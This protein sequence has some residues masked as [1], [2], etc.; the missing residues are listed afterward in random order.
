MH[1]RGRVAQGAV[2]LLS[3]VLACRPAAPISAPAEPVAAAR[4]EP[5]RPTP[6]SAPDR[7]APVRVRPVVSAEAPPLAREFRGVW[8]ASVA[9]IDWPSKRTLSTAQQQAELIALLDRAAALKLNAVLFQIR[10]AA[11]ALYASKIEPWSEYLTGAQGR[12]PVPYWDPLEFAIREAHARHLELHAW[13][14]P[15]RARHTD[16]KSPLARTHIARTNPTLVKPYARY[17]WMDPGEPAVRARTLRVVLDVVKRYDV[18]GVHIDDYFYPY[19][20]NDRRGRAI[21]FPDDRSWKRY[22]REGGELSRA[23]WRRRNVDLLVQALDEG[24]HKAKP[25]VRF[26]ISPFGIWRPGY[27][28]Q[29]RGFDAYEKLY[30]DA[31]KWLREGWVDYFTPQLYWPTTKREQA[32]PA[33]LDWWV[34]ENVMG[35]HMWPGNFTS[36][37]GGVGSGAFSVGELVEQIRVTRLQDGATGN[38]HFSMKSFLTNQAG[39][40]DTLL[41]GPYASTALVPATPWLKAA[42]PPLPVARLAETTAGTRLLLRTTGTAVPWQYA[43]RLRTDTAWITMVVSGSTTAWTIPK[44]TSPTAVSVVSLNRVGTQSAPVTIPFPSRTGAAAGTT[45]TPARGRSDAP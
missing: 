11:D 13:F 1:R 2:L 36:R 7:A 40:N 21:P 37:A 34:S 45:P 22:V 35:R 28:T 4:P 30:A 19:P 31:R 8:V 24:V 32:Y 29:V 38:V 25:W 42:A 43:I 18:D 16:A 12:A 33:L 10:P 27:P 17:L 3:A 5:S 26:G 41:V 39:M 14:N 15:Y 9:N 6:A 20:E 44:G 23:D